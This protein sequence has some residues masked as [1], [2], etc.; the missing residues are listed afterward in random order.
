[1]NAIKQ[2]ILQGGSPLCALLQ[3]RSPRKWPDTAHCR[4][5]PIGD[6]R[7]QSKR[8]VTQ[9]RAFSEPLVTIPPDVAKRDNPDC[10]ECLSVTR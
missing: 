2:E 6:V 9:S 10:A 4:P 1:M 5:Q 3:E 7:S 8:N